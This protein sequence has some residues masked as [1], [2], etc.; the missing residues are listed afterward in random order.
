MKKQPPY[1]HSLSVLSFPSQLN[2]ARAKAVPIPLCYPT[3]ALQ[4]RR[5][6]RNSF[7]CHLRT[8]V[9]GLGGHESVQRTL[10]APLLHALH[11]LSQSSPGVLLHDVLDLLSKPSQTGIFPS[12][13]CKIFIYYY[14]ASAA[15]RVPRTP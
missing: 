10:A 7:V 15:S 11:S 3:P 14:C 12:N 1:T 9:Q 8:Q 4:N 6:Q 13:F 2:T 5:A